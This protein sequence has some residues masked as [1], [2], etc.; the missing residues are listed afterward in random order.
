MAAVSSIIAG[1]AAAVGAIGTANQ[2]DSSRRSANQQRD[3][4][5]AAA[6]QAQKQADDAAKQADMENNKLNQKKPDQGMTGVP[7]GGSTMLT[8]AQGIDSSKLTLGKSTLLGG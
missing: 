4:A 7:A 6:Q 1:I 5:N 8:G 3:A 2:I